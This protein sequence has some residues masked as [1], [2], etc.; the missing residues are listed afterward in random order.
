MDFS[1]FLKLV[2]IIDLSKNN[3]TQITQTLSVN[4]GKKNIKY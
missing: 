1:L 4:N 3:G 2:N